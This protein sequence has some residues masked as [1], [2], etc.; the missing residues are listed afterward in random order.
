MYGGVGAMVAGL[1]WGA[2]V[3]AFMGLFYVGFAF[4]MIGWLFV[5]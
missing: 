1:V 3:S 2:F 4:G 5:K